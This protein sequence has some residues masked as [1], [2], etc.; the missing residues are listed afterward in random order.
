MVAPSGKPTTEQTPRPAAAQQRR[1]QSAHPGGVDA[2]GGELELGRLAAQL[3]DVVRGRVGLEQRV[4]DHRCERRSEPPV[5][6]QA[7]PRGAG[8]D[9]A[10][11]AIGTAIE[12]HGVARA[13]DGGRASRPAARTS[14]T[15]TSISRVRSAVD[16]GCCGSEGRGVMA[17]VLGSAACST[18]RHA[19]SRLHH[20]PGYRP[21]DSGTRTR[22]RETTR[23]SRPCIS[24]ACSRARSCSCRTW[25]V[26]SRPRLAATSWRS[27]ATRKGTTTSGE[28]RLLKDLDTALDGRNV[29]HRR[30]HR[31]HRADAHLS[32]GHPARAR[33]RSRCGPRA[34]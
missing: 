3:L 7:Q 25:C 26:R 5:R 23:R 18:D 10:A 33:S 14:S 19:D 29:D 34:C 12:E 1:A 28:V 13:P 17:S 27:R 11:E 2:H 16:N 9:H 30:G 31:R 32:A 24:S 4:I 20:E 22:D 6:V 15:T 8:V 21:P